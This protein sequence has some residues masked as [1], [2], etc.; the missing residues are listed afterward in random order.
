[1]R[2]YDTDRTD[3]NAVNHF[4]KARSLLP[5]ATHEQI[6]RDMGSVR[7]AM[8]SISAGASPRR[9][10]ERELLEASANTLRAILDGL[11]TADKARDI[12]GLGSAVTQIAE[13]IDAI[14]AALGAAT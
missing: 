11:V 13:M 10:P 14:R 8:R 4:A 1:M 6:Y 7:D 3:P 9:G 12:R 2:N 5:N